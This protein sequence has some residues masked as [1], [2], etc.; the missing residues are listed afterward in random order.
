M[1]SKETKKQLKKEALALKNA[2]DVL[3]NVKNADFSNY[4]E[5][6][7]NEVFD[8]KMQTEKPIKDNRKFK[9]TPIIATSLAVILVAAMIVPLVVWNSNGKI[10]NYDGLQISGFENYNDIGTGIKTESSNQT[11]NVSLQEYSYSLSSASLSSTN[12]SKS[13]KNSRKIIG[14]KTDGNIEE[15]KLENENNDVIEQN[16]NTHILDA[17]FFENFILI[18]TAS[19]KGDPD[20]YQDYESSLGGQFTINYSIYGNS[21]YGISLSDKL[22]VYA[23]SCKTGEIKDITGE[24][25]VIRPFDGYDTSYMESDD[26]VYFIGFTNNSPKNKLNWRLGHSEVLKLGHDENNRIKLENVLINGSENKYVS[27]EVENSSLGTINA[28]SSDTIIYGFI[29]SKVDRYGN[30]F[31]LKD[32]FGYN[33]S[34]D[35]IN[36]SYTTYAYITVGGDLIETNYPLIKAIDGKLYQNDKNDIWESTSNDG[37]NDIVYVENLVSNQYLDENGTLTTGTTMKIMPLKKSYFITSK[38]GYDYYSYGIRDH[39]FV[40]PN[41]YKVKDLEITRVWIDNSPE[42]HFSGA[43]EKDGTATNKSIDANSIC[44]CSSGKLYYRVTFGV[45][46]NGNLRHDLKQP[47]DSDIITED[48]LQIVSFKHFIRYYDIFTGIIHTFDLP[49]SIDNYHL[50]DNVFGVVFVRE[51]DWNTRHAL[52]PDG[53]IQLNYRPSFDLDGLVSRIE[54]FNKNER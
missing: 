7:Q 17:W 12:N 44:V 41:V 47:N 5:L 42:E 35:V 30:I 36:H 53:A 9:L 31:G 29:P 19:G 50:S 25:D 33:V 4:K 23:I 21:S 1:K 48:G 2:P 40:K 3:N 39:Q 18:Y 24:Y 28:P 6:P 34:G 52:L 45:D 43:L 38:D 51:S 11:T 14:Q 22:Q 15:V 20:R 8:V 54:D 46:T 10:I 49:E 13:R 16:I 26:S 32:Y 27:V 37:F